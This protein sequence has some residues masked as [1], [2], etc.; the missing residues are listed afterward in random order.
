MG[1]PFF[2]S[3]RRARSTRAGRLLSKARYLFWYRSIRRV[4]PSAIRSVQARTDSPADFASSTV[5][6]RDKLSSS[7]KGRKAGVASVVLLLA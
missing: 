6:S 3:S 5:F 1:P 7:E 4:S 2:C